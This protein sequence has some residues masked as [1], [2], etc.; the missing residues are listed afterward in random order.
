M[1]A[2]SFALTVAAAVFFALVVP[3]GRSRHRAQ[4]RRVLPL[5]TAVVFSAVGALVASRQPRNAIGWLLLAIGLVG[6]L[7]AFS[8]RVRDVRPARPPRIAAGDDRRYRARASR[9]VDLVHAG[10]DVSAAALSRRAPALP[11]VAPCRLALRSPHRRGAWRSRSCRRAPSR[12]SRRSTTRW[13]SA[14]TPARRSRTRPTTRS[15]R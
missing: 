10:G 5:S 3:D 15:C 8:G 2:F 12:L 9:D 7:T 4:R 14:A 1:W 6:A 11:S 13:A